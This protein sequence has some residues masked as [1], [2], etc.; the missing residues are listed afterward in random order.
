M[1]INLKDDVVSVT[2]FARNTR[3]HTEQIQKSGGHRILTQNGKAALVVLSVDA[4]EELAHAAEE[5]RLDLRLRQALA[6]YAAGDR[7]KPADEMFKSV[8]RNA[9]RRRKGGK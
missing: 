1:K 3:D 4:Y 5:H 7:G 6:D 2:E 9:T 8:R